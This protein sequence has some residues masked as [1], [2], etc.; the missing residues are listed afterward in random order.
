VDKQHP[1]PLRARVVR[2]TRIDTTRIENPRA[3]LPI[4]GVL[5][6]STVPPPR[7]RA[8]G[9]DVIQPPARRAPDGA[10]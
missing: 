3:F 6:S 10:D 2:A 1:P 8:I 4:T 7:A 9:L 5:A